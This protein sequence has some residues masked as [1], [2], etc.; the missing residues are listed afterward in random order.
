METKRQR[1]PSKYLSIVASSAS[2]PVL[3]SHG[4]EWWPMPAL[5]TRRRTGLEW[6]MILEPA[7]RG[8]R[9][10]LQPPHSFSRCTGP[11][12]ADAA[13]SATAGTEQ[14][15]PPPQYFLFLTHTSVLL[16]AHTLGADPPQ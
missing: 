4:S 14:L 11:R 8:A 15:S 5:I 7:E 12:S 16:A 1:V 10:D 2:S 9:R 13:S 6:G 3:P